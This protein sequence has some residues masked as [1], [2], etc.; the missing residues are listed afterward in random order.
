MGTRENKFK[1]EKNCPNRSD[2]SFL[3]LFDRYFQVF[4]IN[5]KSDMFWTFVVVTNYLL[6][7]EI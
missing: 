7:D 2:V 4:H 5:F 3:V 6:G 1:V